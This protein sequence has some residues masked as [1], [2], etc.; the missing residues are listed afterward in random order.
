MAVPIG[1]LRYRP[2]AAPA[3]EAR[4]P[5]MHRSKR[6]GCL[7]LATGALVITA[8]AT[9]LVYIEGQ[10]APTGK[11]EYVALGSSFAAGAGLG[12]LQKES[13][14]LCARSIN[15]YPQQLARMMQLS[16]VDMSCGG[17]T[18][19][20]V[21]SGG[22]LFQG[23]Q[24]RVVNAQTRLVT[25]TVGGNDIDYIGD[26]SLSAARNSTTMFGWLVRHFWSGPK[27]AEQRDYV[28]LR[29][30][31]IGI[32]YVIQQRAPG[33][34]IVLATYPTILPGSGTCPVLGLKT[35]EADLMREVAGELAS[36]TRSAA[37]ETGAMLVDMNVIGVS[38]NACSS[39]PWTR[40]WTN[41]GIAPFHPTLAGAKATA[42]AIVEA[43]QHSPAGIAAVGEDNASSHQAR[44]IGREKQD[45]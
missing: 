15:G 11:P 36:A 34:K 31:L 27:P 5:S 32:I 21:L 29:T 2:F 26:L 45:D 16:I 42:N 38:H 3:L 9:A 39:D 7:F 18:A 24:L 43:L 33:A 37:Q 12:P 22:Q 6:S 40:G 23:P 10:R 14:H 8:A 19:R 28:K 30:N 41:G 4:L 20:H 17:A 25:I 13:P 1:L 44:G 35:R